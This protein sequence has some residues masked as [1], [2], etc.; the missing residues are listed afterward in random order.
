MPKKNQKN[1]TPET[2]ET[3]APVQVETPAE[4]EEAP[5][6]QRGELG[7]ATSALTIKQMWHAE[8]HNL[9]DV[10][11]KHNPRKQLSVKRT[12]VPSLKQYARQLAASGNDVAKDWFGNKDGA[13]DAKRSEKNSAR[14]TLE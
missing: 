13:K 7:K 11:D 3:Q 2:Q 1:E 6:G 10:G 5:V 8:H 9:Q 12:G 14:I 4:P